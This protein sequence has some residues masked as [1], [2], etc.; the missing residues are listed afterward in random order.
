MLRSILLT[1]LLV[2]APSASAQWSMSQ[3]MA[4]VVPTVVEAAATDFSDL[5]GELLASNGTDSL[6]VSAYA[7]EGPGGPLY[8]Q[9]D[10]R[11]S[12]G[13]S[14]FWF[15]IPGP[16]D[17]IETVFYQTVG[18]ADTALGSNEGDDGLGW[19]YQ[20]TDLDGGRL[21]SQ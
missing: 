15:S 2:A 4:E 12:A 13:E 6:W 17:V 19:V 8:A 14:A 5:R 1:A 21:V 7:P 10:H 9:T 11:V 20:Q 18:V 16:A 3:M